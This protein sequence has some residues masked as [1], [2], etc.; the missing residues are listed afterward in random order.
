MQRRAVQRQQESVIAGAAGGIPESPVICEGY[1]ELC[2]CSGLDG[3]C[4]THALIGPLQAL[5]V[6]SPY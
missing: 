1:P 2:V 3:P 5:E 4:V 6:S